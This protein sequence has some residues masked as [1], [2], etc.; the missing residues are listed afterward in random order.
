MSSTRVGP[1]GV[2]PSRSRVTA[3]V[4]AISRRTGEAHRAI[5]GRMNRATGARS[6]GAA[7]AEQLEKGNRLLEK[8]ARRG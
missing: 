6:V 8:E 7:T 1:V 2:Q 4:A 3:L 5:H